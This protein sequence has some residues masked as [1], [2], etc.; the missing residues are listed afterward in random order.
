MMTQ[1]Q[2][3]CCDRSAQLPPTC[4]GGYRWHAKI[5]TQDIN[6]SDDLIKMICLL[7]AAV[8]VVRIPMVIRTW[9]N[10]MV[11]EAVIL[12]FGAAASVLQHTSDAIDDKV[13]GVT[14]RQWYRLN[15]LFEMSNNFILSDFVNS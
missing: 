2:K 9:R 14:P 3:F 13:F 7:L 4:A 12:A 6:W 8:L 10:S 5:M 11:Y 1:R 15:N